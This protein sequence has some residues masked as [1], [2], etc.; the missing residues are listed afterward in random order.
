MPQGEHNPLTQHCDRLCSS[1]R[2]PRLTLRE[3]VDLCRILDQCGAWYFLVRVRD[4]ARQVL[5]A[6]VPLCSSQGTRACSHTRRDPRPVPA[7]PYWRVSSSDV[8]SR[9]FLGSSQPRRT[10]PRHT[11]CTVQYSTVQYSAGT[12]WHSESIESAEPVKR[13]A[14]AS[15]SPLS[16][17]L[18][19]GPYRVSEG[20][21][22]PGRSSSLLHISVSEREG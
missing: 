15:V 4:T 5:V 13:K 17:P 1:G 18:H 16:Q 19:R 7:S 6:N 20:M 8:H 9:A 11:V 10:P 3:G 12:V 22:E 14:G 2:R 21:F